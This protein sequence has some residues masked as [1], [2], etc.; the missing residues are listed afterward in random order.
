VGVFEKSAKIQGK[1]CEFLARLQLETSLEKLAKVHPIGSYAL[2]L[3]T[4]NDIDLYL[5]PLD[6]PKKIMRTL[7]DTMLRHPTCHRVT[8]TNATDFFRQGHPLAHN[9]GVIHRFSNG[10]DWKI[11]IAIFD[12]P[13]ITQTLEQNKKFLSLIDERMRQDIL[14]IKFAL[15]EKFG[16]VPKAGSYYIYQAVILQKLPKEQVLRYLVDKGVS[17]T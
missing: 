11:D 17:L 13:T 1:A 9:M 8:Y 7:F 4:W 2:S 16:R 14:E 5:E 6:S 3:M 12:K 10:E 15:V